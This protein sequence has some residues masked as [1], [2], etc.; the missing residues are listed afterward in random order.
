MCERRR[1]RRRGARRG[2]RSGAATMPQPSTLRLI[3]NAAALAAA[4]P[5]GRNLEV[6]VCLILQY[7]LQSCSRGG[8]GI[9][10]TCATSDDEAHSKSALVVRLVQAHVHPS[11]VLLVPRRVGI[12]SALLQQ[13][14]CDVVVDV[15]LEQI[16]VCEVHMAINVLQPGRLAKAMSWYWMKPSWMWSSLSTSSTMA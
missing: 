13:C 2:A 8:R 10:E 5:T 3:R 15:L 14:R 9:A 7:L 16:L 6:C 11:A 1:G 4:S 12:L